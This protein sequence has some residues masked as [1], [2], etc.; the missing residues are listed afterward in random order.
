MVPGG[1]RAGAVTVPV[2]SKPVHPG[3]A[4]PGLRL[5][6]SRAFGAGPGPLTPVWELPAV[7]VLLPSGQG[8]QVVAAAA[9]LDHVVLEARANT[10]LGWGQEA[11]MTMVSPPSPRVGPGSWSQG[12]RPPPC[13]VA[14]RWPSC[15][16]PGP[17]AEV[18]AQRT[19]KADMGHTPV[20]RPRP[21]EPLHRPP[22]GQ[23][24]GEGTGGASRLLLGASGLPG[25]AAL[26]CQPGGREPGLPRRVGC[27]E[28]PGLAHS[29]PV[30][31]PQRPALCLQQ[32][33]PPS[34]PRFTR[35]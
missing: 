7:A 10:G 5:P 33:L 32:R 35:G 23:L 34:E 13:E 11:A 4:G 18:L 15:S 24:G 3:P 28:S 16:G 9:V 2:L 21:P 29:S 12:R 14:V 6:G 27:E 1:C 25:G 26:G 20:T 22:G 31:S 30:A 17:L 19:G 8:V